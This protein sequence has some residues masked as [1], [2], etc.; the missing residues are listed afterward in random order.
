MNICNMIY[1]SLYEVKDGISN[2]VFLSVVQIGLVNKIFGPFTPVS[3][4]YE[5]FTKI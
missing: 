5:C 4:D 2:K 3:C 1:L